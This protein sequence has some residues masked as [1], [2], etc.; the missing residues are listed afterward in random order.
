MIDD[1]IK[2]ANLLSFIILI[3]IILI[4]TLIPIS[5]C[6]GK[7]PEIVRVFWQINLVDDQEKD[8]LYQSLTL[9]VQAND[10][11][12][13]EDLEEIYLINDSEELFWCIDSESWLKSTSGDATWIGSSTISMPD[14][15]PLPAGEYRIL[16]Q[17]IG[18][19]EA[20]Q[21]IFLKPSLLKAYRRYIPSVSI[22]NGEIL[23][24][25]RADSYALWLYNKDQNYFR[26]LPVES[27]SVSI[28]EIVRTN[29]ALKEGF[30]FR[31][32]TYL[33]DK[34]LGLITGPYYAVP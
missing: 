25:G 9:F 16:L 3:G 28:Q 32:Y 27:K 21:T 2:K 20:E 14:G 1:L 10:P 17:D 24:S 13:F 34:S 23:V 18:G 33:E 19:D 8:I 11:D 7:P 30:S 4:G 29:N 31:V 22:E 6:T 12:G 26:S 15:S 5:G